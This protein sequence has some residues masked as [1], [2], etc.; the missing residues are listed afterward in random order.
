M[1]HLDTTLLSNLVAAAGRMPERIFYASDTALAPLASG[2][3]TSTGSLALMGLGTLV[4]YPD[5]ETID[6]TFT[7][8]EQRGVDHGDW[9]VRLVLGPAVAL[10]TTAT[11]WPELEGEGLR[12]HLSEQVSAVPGLLIGAADNELMA[13]RKQVGG[14]EA[15]PLGAGAMH[16]CFLVSEDAIERTGAVPPAGTTHTSSV[17]VALSGGDKALPLTITITK[18]A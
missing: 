17:L 2:A 10:D 18:T 13:I 6:Q 11:G 3:K 15:G 8:L 9:T 4:S 7:G 5:V 14:E 12:A 16:A 1:Q